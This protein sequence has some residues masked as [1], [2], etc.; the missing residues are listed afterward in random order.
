MSFSIMNTF[1]INPCGV[2]TVLSKCKISYKEEIR[3]SRVELIIHVQE[4]GSSFDNSILDRVTSN[5]RLSGHHSALPRDT[6]D[7]AAGL[8]IRFRPITP[9]MYLLR[10]LPSVVPQQQAP[11]SYLL[12]SSR[13]LFTRQ[14]LVFQPL[15]ARPIRTMSDDVSIHGDRGPVSCR[16]FS[17]FF[18]FFISP[19]CAPH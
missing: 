5:L 11:V 10:V 6:T 19:T 13:S 9:P 2:K 8:A 14:R 18:P 7:I 4:I 12:D 15:Y 1:F 17:D 3:F 16:F